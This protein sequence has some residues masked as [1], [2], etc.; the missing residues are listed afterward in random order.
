MTDAGEGIFAISRRLMVNSLAEKALHF[1][2]STTD[3]E[4]ITARTFGKFAAE[5][6]DVG[7]W[8]DAYF[9]EHWSKIRH[10]EEFEDFFVKL[11]SDPEEYI[12]VNTKFRKLIME[13][14]FHG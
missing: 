1:I 7:K 6:D 4:N 13:R 10:G 8:F 12:R 14:D 11:E 3:I 9:I 5:H 2:Q